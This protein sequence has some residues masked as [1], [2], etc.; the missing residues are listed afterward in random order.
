MT[1]DTRKVIVAGAESP[2]AYLVLAAI[3]DP[4]VVVS[5]A[6]QIEYLNPAAEDFFGASAGFLIGQELEAIAPADGTLYALTENAL[7][8]GTSVAEHETELNTPRTGRRE[9]SFQV[10]PLGDAPGSVLLTIREQTMASRMGSQLSHRDAARSVTGMA[11]VLAHEVKNPLAGISGAA[12]LL[13]AGASEDDREL[14]QLIRAESD[15][16]CA[17]IDSMERFSDPRPLERGP[18]NVH[19]VLD[20]ARKVAEAG[21]AADTVFEERYDPSLPPVLGN[22]DQLVQVVL[23]LIKNAVEA[24]E[25]LPCEI[26]MTT[27]YRHGLRLGVPGTQDQVHLPLEI[28]VQDNGPGIGEDVRRHMFDPFVTTKR[29]GTGLGLSLVAK[30]IGDHSGL[31][32]C[33]SEPGRTVFRVRLPVAAN[34]ERASRDAG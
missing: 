19:Q 28:T 9:V 15:R 2:D 34:D 22:R 26:V 30:I 16:I 3:P 13:E 1:A 23:N 10:T 5:P 27:A 17:L 21:F 7:L 14:T 29:S 8:R 6:K 18:V 11:A 31:I 32:E 20:H 25:S 4:L 12:Q 33:D 24:N